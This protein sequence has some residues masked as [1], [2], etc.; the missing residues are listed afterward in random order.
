[1]GYTSGGSVAGGVASGAL[2]FTGGGEATPLYF[3]IG[4]VLI[5]AGIVMFIITQRRKHRDQLAV[6]MR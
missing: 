3:V 1:M 4:V 6:E 2:A 5:M